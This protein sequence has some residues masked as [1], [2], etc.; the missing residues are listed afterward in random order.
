MPTRFEALTSFIW[1]CFMDVDI[2]FRVKQIDDA[3]IPA[4]AA[5]DPNQVQYVACFAITLRTR[6]IPP[7]PDNTFGNMTDNAIVEVSRNLTGNNGDQ[8]QYY[9]ESVSKIKDSIKF[10]DNEHVK[11]MKRNF[12]ISCNHMKLHQMLKE[13]TFNDDHKE[14]LMF[15]DGIEAWVSLKEE[16]MVEFELHE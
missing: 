6:I 8:R 16:D 9:S 13:G 1:M 4:N 15:R 3:V 7:L 2:R 14:F 5:C 12:A 11:S 10:I